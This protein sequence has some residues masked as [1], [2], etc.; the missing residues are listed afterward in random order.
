M[1]TEYFPN[2]RIEMDIYI[3]ETQKTSNKL[4]ANRNTL[5]NIITELLNVKDRRNFENS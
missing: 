5:R 1:V 2:L 3:H 4:Y